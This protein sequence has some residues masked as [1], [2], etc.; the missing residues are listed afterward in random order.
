MEREMEKNPQATISVFA[1]PMPPIS[2]ISQFRVPSRRSSGVPT[3][4][5]DPGLLQKKTKKHQRVIFIRVGSRSR[6]WLSHGFI[7][8]EFGYWASLPYIFIHRHRPRHPFIPRLL[9]TS[10]LSTSLV[11]TITIHSCPDHPCDWGRPQLREDPAV[12]VYRRCGLYQSEFVEVEV[13]SFTGL[14]PRIEST[15]PK[16]HR[17]HPLPPLPPRFLR[18]RALLPTHN[19]TRSSSRAPSSPPP[20][21]S[22]PPISCLCFPWTMPLFVII[23]FFITNSVGDFQET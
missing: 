4:R 7:E 3:D 10:A 22:P 2:S 11:I 14:L 18:P 5:P 8:F 1:A 17:H 6:T 20:P 9:P 21:P 16:P 13:G 15:S 19:W 23:V 12:L